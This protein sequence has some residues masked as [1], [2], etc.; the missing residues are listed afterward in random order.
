MDASGPPPPSS[1]GELVPVP[2]SGTTSGALVESTGVLPNLEP[3]LANIE[4]IAI[5]KTL[6][7]VNNF[8]INTVDFCNKFSVL[9]ERKLAKISQNI[10][11]IEIVLALLEAKLESVP[12]LN[13]SVPSGGGGV[14]T[15]APAPDMSGAPPPPI[16]GAPPPPPGA[17]QP[18]SD[19]PPPPAASFIKLKDDDRY[20]KYFKMIEMGIQKEA[21][22]AR[23]SGDGLDPAVLD[24]NPEGPA[25]A[26]ASSTSQALV[27]VEMREPEDSDDDDD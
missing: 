2:A 1:G 9:S 5:K 18:G 17:P 13:G 14:P 24:M 22:Y 20:K 10:Q 21:L 25:P 4:P 16:D 11:R 3:A 19:A 12:W 23:V 6:M 27:E 8:I 26:G 15:S 7:I